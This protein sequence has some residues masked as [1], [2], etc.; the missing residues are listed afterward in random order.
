MHSSVAQLCH[1]VRLPLGKQFALEQSA[2][3]SHLFI[4]LTVSSNDRIFLF[5]REQ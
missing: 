5:S 2:V 3:L 4:M 1:E